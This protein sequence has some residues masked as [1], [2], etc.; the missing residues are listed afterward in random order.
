M[1]WNVCP[2]NILFDNKGY[3]RLSDFLLARPFSDDNAQDSSGNPQYMGPEIIFRQ[4]HDFTC[5][6]YALGVIGY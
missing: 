2:S 4:V 1:H 3:L 6:Y 5:D